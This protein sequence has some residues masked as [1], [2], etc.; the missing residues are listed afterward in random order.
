MSVRES[1]SAKAAAA[2]SRSGVEVRTG[3]VVDAAGA[4]GKAL[5]KPEAAES[6]TTAGERAANSLG[7]ARRGGSARPE[8]GYAT[9]AQVVGETM[10]LRFAVRRVGDPEDRGGV[11]GH[12]GPE[13]FG[14]GEGLSAAGADG[15]P[16]PED[17]PRRGDPEAHHR[18]S[19]SSCSSHGARSRPMPWWCEIV[20]PA[21]RIAV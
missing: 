20:P 13:A 10:L 17:R 9:P 15:D 7:S 1:A 18:I 21:S 11:D 2:L 16:T 3:A 19:H 12:E 8:H 6:P 4:P 14:R 5:E